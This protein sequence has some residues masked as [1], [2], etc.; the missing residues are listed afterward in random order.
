MPICPALAT[1]GDLA[2]V[3]ATTVWGTAADG[4][5]LIDM[6]ASITTN[7]VMNRLRQEG[8]K[9]PGPWAMTA[10]GEATD[11]PEALFSVPPGTLLPAG[12]KDHGHK[13]YGM[14]LTVEALSQGLSGWERADPPTG[15]G[16]ALFVQA[17]DPELY[18]GAQSF[19]RQT[20]FVAE[21]CRS[22]PPAPGIE[23][24][25]LPGDAALARKAHALRHGVQL[26][27][28]IWDALGP[29]AAKLRVTPPEPLA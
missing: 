26:Y 2:F 7:G 28:G 18:E 6:S 8:R 1:T 22:N 10:A 11:N 9:F 13:G 14:A 27:P 12:G 5:I 21:T 4:P 29:W 20:T 25:R 23:S 16:A 3:P 24:V 15:W 19:L 17:M